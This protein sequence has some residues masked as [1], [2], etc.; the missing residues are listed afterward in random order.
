M[1]L[2]VLLLVPLL[3]RT[4]KA[5]SQVSCMTYPVYLHKAEDEVENHSALVCLLHS[6][7]FTGTAQHSTAQQSTAQHSTAHLAQHGKA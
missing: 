6:M 3:G 5:S 2:L 7:T 1:P 4:H